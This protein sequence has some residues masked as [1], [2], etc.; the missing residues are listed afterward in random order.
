MHVLIIPSWYPTHPADIGGSFFRE[1]ALALH[2]Y[3]C[4]V[5]VIYPQHRS[6]RQWAKIWSGKH[7]I[8]L[9]IDE[10][11]PT[12]RYHGTNWF[13]RMPRF[14]R[15]RWIRHGWKLFNE[16]IMQY[17]KPDVIHVHSILNAGILARELHNQLGIPFV[18]TEHSSAYARQS[19]S[20]SDLNVAQTAVNCAKKKF[21]VSNEFGRLLDQIFTDGDKWQHMPNIVHELFFDK[22]LES[23]KNNCFEFINV[24]LADK[25]KAQAN[26]LEAFAN[27]FKNKNNVRLI[28]GGDGPELENLK[29]L[30]LNL[31]IGAQVKFTGLLTREQVRKKI[32]QSSAFVLSS[33]YETFGVV[34]IE[35]LALG[36]PVVATRCGGPDSIV[37]EQDGLLVPVDD[38]PSLE[39][40]MQSIYE[41]RTAYN[42]VEIRAACKERF[43]EHAIAERLMQ[44]YE[45]I[46]TA[47]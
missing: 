42:A 9:Q 40:A 8:E 11:M 7:G 19:I 43:S 34:L 14:A 39:A 20:L 6:L 12:L 17:G 28:I 31:G 46:Y 4:K 37:R 35:A 29:A 26:I 33:R 10:G 47:H 22:E 38:V 5:G 45:E 23:S 25:N 30:A 41:N 13:P 36:K 21:A 1:Q 15:T 27:R 3:G 18:I 16:Y 44:V 2:K 24:A 32:A